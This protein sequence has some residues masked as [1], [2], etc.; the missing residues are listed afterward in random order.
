MAANFPLVVE[1][2]RRS[3]TDGL[4]SI[5]QALATIAQNHPLEGPA[6]GGSVQLAQQ[7]PNNFGG[8]VVGFGVNQWLDGAGQSLGC[9]ETQ[10]GVQEQIGQ[11]VVHVWLGRCRRTLDN[12]DLVRAVD[13][14]EVDRNGPGSHLILAMV[15]RISHEPQVHVFRCR[16]FKLN[17][18]LR[19][20]TRRLRAYGYDFIVYSFVLFSLEPQLAIASMHSSSATLMAL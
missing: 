4:G 6:R 1:E 3:A 17:T 9:L 7:V 14:L 12:L 13:L 20:A 16:V 18:R 19:I 10:A 5:P 15:R 8:A 2:I 11:A